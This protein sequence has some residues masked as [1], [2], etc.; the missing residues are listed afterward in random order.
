MRAHP[1]RWEVSVEAEDLDPPVGAVRM[2]R[3]VPPD[4]EVAD[5]LR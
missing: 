4:G 2:A 3:A 1:S 5:V